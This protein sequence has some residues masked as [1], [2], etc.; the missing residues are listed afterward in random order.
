M[1][2]VRERG[3]GGKEKRKDCRER[4]DEGCTENY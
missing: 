3:R 1:K 4:K 2:V